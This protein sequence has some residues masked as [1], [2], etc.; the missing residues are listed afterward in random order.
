MKKILGL[1]QALQRPLSGQY[2]RLTDVIKVPAK[3]NV[4]QSKTAPS[5][6]KCSRFIVQSHNR[7]S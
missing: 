6:V 1:V 4:M 5:I 7:S 3:G 2:E